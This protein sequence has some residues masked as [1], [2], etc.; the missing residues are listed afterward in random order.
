MI[1][2][3]V[4][5]TSI[6]TSKQI[7]QYGEIILFPMLLGRKSDKNEWERLIQMKKETLLHNS[8]LSCKQLELY[9]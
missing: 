7:I 5:Q 4:S 9:D 6:C 2:I 3:L 1:A 8:T